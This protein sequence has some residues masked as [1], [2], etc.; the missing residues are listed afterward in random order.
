V[1]CHVGKGQVRFGDYKLSLF[2][3]HGV[4]ALIVQQQPRAFATVVRQGKARAGTDSKPAVVPL[5]SAAA[6]CS[7]A[8]CLP[9]SHFVILEHPRC[10]PAAAGKQQ[11]RCRACSGCIDQIRSGQVRSTQIR[12]LGRRAWALQA[13]TEGIHTATRQPHLG[14]RPATRLQ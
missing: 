8:C 7:T 4:R 11:Q 5:C 9:A 10:L 14:D 3:S 1:S 12:L 2:A 6:W 13:I